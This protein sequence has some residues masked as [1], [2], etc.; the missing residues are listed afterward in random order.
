[1]IVNAKFAELASFDLLRGLL[2]VFGRVRLR[3]IPDPEAE[4]DFGLEGGLNAQLDDPGILPGE[5]RQN[6]CFRKA[7]NGWSHAIF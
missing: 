3:L 7:T 5:V 1:M 4:G 2:Q 6:E